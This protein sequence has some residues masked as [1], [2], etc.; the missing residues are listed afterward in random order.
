LLF[1]SF[2]DLVA[3]IYLYGADV[4]NAVICSAI[5][6]PI[7]QSIVEFIMH[8]LFLYFPLI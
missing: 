5:L 4:F 6:Q 8:M 2:H 7:Y 3:L 1:A